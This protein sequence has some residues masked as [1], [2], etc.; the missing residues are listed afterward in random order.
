MKTET[1]KDL[2]SKTPRGLWNAARFVYRGTLRLRYKTAMDLSPKNKTCYCPCCGL[3]FKAFRTGD[4]FEYPDFYDLSLFEGIRQDISCPYCFSLPRHRILASWCE[5]NNA[6]LKDRNILYFA[7]E[8]SMTM[9][10]DRN[11][12]SYKTADLYDKETDLTLDIQKTGLPDASF[13]VVICNHV[14]EHVDD[15]M[16]ALSEVRRI[17]VKGGLFICSFP[18]NTDIDIV[19]EDSDVKTDEDRRRVY[20]QTDHVRLFGS[21]AEIFMEKAG[22][23]VEFIDGDDYPQEIVPVTGPC[24][25]DINRLFLC[26]AVEGDIS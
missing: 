18:V 12:I 19:L 13:D 21:G 14:L 6:L 17:L 1:K 5:K 2:K 3:R 11:G 23:D 25:Y 15:V 22:F 10:M 8:K 24:R 9:W 26:R 7:P 16:A 20:G 4:H